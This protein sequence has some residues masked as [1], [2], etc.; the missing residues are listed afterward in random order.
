MRRVQIKFDGSVE[1]RIGQYFIF[2]PIQAHWKCFDIPTNVFGFNTKG[3]FFFV[4]R[5]K[6]ILTKTRQCNF[7][8]FNIILRVMFSLQKRRNSLRFSCLR[9]TGFKEI[10]DAF[11]LV[12][13]CPSY[14]QHNNVAQ[15]IF[16]IDWSNDIDDRKTSWIPHEIYIIIRVNDN[17]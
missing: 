8:Y 6:R 10:K 15:S 17:I 12:V 14:T 3:S 5:H 1:N 4:N 2:D 16:N 13:L 11:G 7:S 9:L